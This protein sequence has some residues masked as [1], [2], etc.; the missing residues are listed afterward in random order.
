MVYAKSRSA[1][2]AAHYA[3]VAVDDSAS[4]AGFLPFC[5][6]LRPHTTRHFLFDTSIP[7][8]IDKASAARSA[9]D[10]WLKLTKATSTISTRDHLVVS[11]DSRLAATIVNERISVG[12]TNGHVKTNAER[13]SDSLHSGKPKKSSVVCV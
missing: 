13:T 7:P 11:Q 3:S 1:L 10:R 9:R 8:C 5:G 6:R 4:V 2:L 12:L